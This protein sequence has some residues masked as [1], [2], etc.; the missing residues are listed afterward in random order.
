MR[1]PQSSSS[2]ATDPGAWVARLARTLERSGEPDADDLAQDAWLVAERRGF[3]H[4]TPA[5]GR[6]IARRLARDRHIAAG[7]R[8]RREGAVARPEGAPAAASP[9]EQDELRR[10]IE[11]ALGSIAPDRERALRLHYFEGRTPSEIAALEE[12]SADTVRWRLRRGL[13]DLR[14]ALERRHG[15]WSQLAPLLAAVAATRSE[16]SGGGFVLATTTAKAATGVGAL[17]LVLFAALAVIGDIGAQSPSVATPESVAVP[18]KLHAVE[19][20]SASRVALAAVEPLVTERAE[21]SAAPE[22]PAPMAAASTPPLPVADAPALIPGTSSGE[23]ILMAE[24]AGR[25]V[26]LGKPVEGALVI[27]TVGSGDGWGS[28]WRTEVASTRTD[29]SGHFTFG[30]SI[31]VVT[32]T[33]MLFVASE[34]HP[35]R[36][37][38]APLYPANDAELGGAEGHKAAHGLELDLLTGELLNGTLVGPEGHPLPGVPIVALQTHAIDLDGSHSTQL[39]RLEADERVRLGVDLEPLTAVTD[40]RGRFEFDGLTLDR[41][42]LVLPPN[43]RLRGDP[44]LPLRSGHWPLE[45][46]F[47]EHLSFA[48]SEAEFEQLA[49]RR[50]YELGYGKAPKRRSKA[51][52][53]PSELRG[54]VRG[55]AFGSLPTSAGAEARQAMLEALENHFDPTEGQPGALA[56]RGFVDFGA[57][58][59]WSFPSGVETQDFGNE[60]VASFLLD[61]GRA[62]LIQARL[63]E[64]EMPSD[65]QGSL[66]ERAPGAA[67]SLDGIEA[68]P[69]RE[70]LLEH[71]AHPRFDP[72][73]SESLRFVDTRGVPVQAPLVLTLI[74]W[75]GNAV[76]LTRK[77]DPNGAL[78]LDLLPYR[79]LQVRFLD[80]E[81]GWPTPVVERRP[82]SR[83]SGSRQ[84]V[85]VFRPASMTI[86]RP[87]GLEGPWSLRLRTSNS[88]AFGRSFLV[89]EDRF[90][91]EAIA[92]GRWFVARGPEGQDVD[93]EVVRLAPGK[94]ARLRP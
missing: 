94:H 78:R 52:P 48:A 67:F 82:A 49:E 27:A 32:A 39:T 50:L 1:S 42:Q 26:A 14:A 61:K 69:L 5:L 35:N 6:G 24:L 74:P 55:I 81:T 62:E 57:G 83:V 63:R 10:S 72:S 21:E 88:K 43:M 41:A 92:P 53:A 73:A 29:A 9:L 15:G 80:D 47:V 34:R 16:A 25:V 51:A 36:W 2:T 87:A 79:A 13:R 30:R 20:S 91:I 18:T 77:P 3:R 75:S 37:F 86:E 17:A 44:V 59:G 23:Q 45:V 54:M 85:V 46:E 22:P 64:F 11:A 65:V 70:T 93:Q 60:W 66:L 33:A 19:P 71:V 31:G 68:R 56:W 84:T 4:L 7:R 38:E 76:E 8:A 89:D 58:D 90:E 40:K 12:V 28:L